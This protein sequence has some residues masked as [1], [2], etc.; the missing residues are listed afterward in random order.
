MES[1]SLPKPAPKRKAAEPV[2]RKP[3]LLDDLG[4]LVIFSLKALR[5]VPG[6]LR[7]AS[8]IMR[9][10]ALITR[11]TTLL[12][13]VM[14]MFLGISLTN[15]G[16]FFLRSI[17]ASDYAGIVPGLTTAKM[18]GPQ[19]FGYV[20]AGSVC[21]A[22]AAELGSARIQ[23]EISAYESE[24][25]D[26]MEMLIGTR[27]I[28]VLLYVPLAT[29]VAIAGCIAGGY[30]IVVVVLKGNSGVQFLDAFFSIMPM[31]SI[32][33]MMVTVALI[34][35]QCVLVACYY[36]MKDLGGGPDAVGNAV[37]QSLALNLVL[38]HFVLSLCA[39]FFYGAT[40]EVPIGD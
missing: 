15:F 18:I 9:L 27:I 38:L 6:S 3:G 23:Q 36:G 24:G 34:T 8:E 14:C 5:A 12:L 19:M 35:L 26:P 1:A 7:Y 33:F 30:T 39:L 11:R 10:N 29:L 2:K 21:C 17:G 25:V 31:N 13:F 32:L 40:L 22:I 20:F 28:A 4:Q 16:F 37:A